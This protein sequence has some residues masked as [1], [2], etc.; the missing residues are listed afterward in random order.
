MSFDEGEEGGD[1]EKQAA[2]E[3]PVETIEIS[4]SKVKG[5]SELDWA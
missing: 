2:G 3:C 4:N 1:G 5:E